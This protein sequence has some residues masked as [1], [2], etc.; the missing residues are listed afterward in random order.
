[1]RK[2][3]LPLLTGL[4]LMCGQFEYNLVALRK[5]T[6]AGIRLT[7]KICC[8]ALALTMTNS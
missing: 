2:S 3:S 1:M 7:C 5:V 8:S 4:D 6:V